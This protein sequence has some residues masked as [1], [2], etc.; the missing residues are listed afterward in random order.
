MRTTI[1]IP[2]ELRKKLVEEAAARNL[3]GFSSLIVEALRLY[4]GRTN[5]SRE[6][7]IEKLKGSMSREQ[8]EE[9]RTRLREVRDNWRK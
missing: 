6:S 5:A 7:V 4:F 2:P 1:D 8:L 9:E 3:R